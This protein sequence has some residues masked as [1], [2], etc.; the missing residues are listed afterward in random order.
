QWGVTATTLGALG[1]NQADGKIGSADE[2]VLP[3]DSLGISS[4]PL[5]RRIGSSDVEAVREMTSL[6]SRADQRRGGGHGLSAVMAYLKSDVI[7][8]LNGVYADES[9]RCDMLSAAENSPTW[10]DG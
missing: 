4:R 10:S 1:V 5:S 2:F 3:E 7:A 6:F 8:Q 9:T